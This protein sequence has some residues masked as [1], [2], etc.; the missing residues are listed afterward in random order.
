MMNYYYSYFWSIIENSSTSGHQFS[1]LALSCLLHIFILMLWS[2][3]LLNEVVEKYILSW[4]LQARRNIHISLISGNMAVWNELSSWNKQLGLCRTVEIWR[5]KH[6]RMIFVTKFTFFV[7][8]DK[9]ILK[10]HTLKL[11]QQTISVQSV[12]PCSMRVW[13]SALW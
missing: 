6:N 8:E 13:D 4:C 11:H 5:L 12:P 1:I 3:L 7:S 2:P 10:P 9:I